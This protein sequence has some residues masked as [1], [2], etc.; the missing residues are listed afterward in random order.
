[1][2]EEAQQAGVLRYDVIHQVSLL[3]HF[4]FANY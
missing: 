4:T 3:V 1:M 2:H